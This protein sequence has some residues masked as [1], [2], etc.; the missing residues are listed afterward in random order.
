MSCFVIAFLFFISTPGQNTHYSKN[1]GIGNACDFNIPKSR[2]NNISIGFS[3]LKDLSTGGE[4]KPLGVSNDE[5]HDFIT[6]DSAIYVKV[7]QWDSARFSFRISRPKALDNRDMIFTVPGKEEQGV[8]ASKLQIWGPHY[9]LN[10]G[11]D[12]SVSL[13]NG[14]HYPI[15]VTMIAREGNT[16]PGPIWD[17]AFLKLIKIYKPRSI[18]LMGLSY[19]SW[20]VSVLAEMNAE[21]GLIKSIAALSGSDNNYPLLGHW[22]KRGGKAFLTVGYADAGNNTKPPLAAKAMQDSSKGSVYFTYNSVNNGLHGDWNTIY[23]PANNMWLTKGITTLVYSGSYKD[24]WNIYQWALRQGDTSLIGSQSNTG[25]IN[26]API[27]FI[28]TTLGSSWVILDGSASY[29]PDGVIDSVW[30]TEI[31]KPEPSK[32]ISDLCGMR[33]AAVDLIPGTYVYNFQ[34]KDNKGAVSN[35]LTSVIISAPV[36]SVI[37]RIPMSTM[38]GIV[39]SSTQYLTIFSDGSYTLQ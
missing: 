20:T 13:S 10:H 8:D 11:W 30:F 24:G 33:L 39:S 5:S 27:P 2:N 1:V 32:M 16:Y 23:N 14:K 19:G 17:S 18:H 6:L 38:I 34:I 4:S 22:A 7:N 21:T 35:L 9:W 26:K 3:Y 15:L 28:K 12:G 29:D 25:S 37:L 36:K 31:S